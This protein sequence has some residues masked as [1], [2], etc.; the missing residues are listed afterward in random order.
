MS[1]IASTV[2]KIQP[3]MRKGRPSAVLKKKRNAATHTKTLKRLNSTS[4]ATIN[5]DRGVSCI[6]VAF[7]F[8]TNS[9]V[10]QSLRYCHSRLGMNS[11]RAAS[12][13]I[14]GQGVIRSLRR[15]V[16]IIPAAMPAPRNRVVCLFSSDSPATTPMTTHHRG[17]SSRHRETSRCA[18]ASQKNTSKQGMFKK[19]PIRS[20]MGAQMKLSAARNSPKRPAPIRR[21]SQPVSR[22][23]TPR[24]SAGKRRS[25]KRFTPKSPVA[26]RA[27]RAMNGGWST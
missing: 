26:T 6:S 25:A 11:S 2:A 7:R 8:R 14:H 9:R 27:T 23:F 10:A 5:W 17:L 21:A 18:A 22:Q 16:M 3:N 24:M 19:A 4:C 12:P 1:M 20:I 13:P 15:W